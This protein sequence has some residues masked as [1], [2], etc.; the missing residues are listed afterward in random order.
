MGEKWDYRFLDMAK[1]VSTW[2][3]DPSTKVGA[4]IVDPKNRIVSVGYNGFPK[5]IK[6]NERLNSRELKYDIVLHAEQNCIL[7]ANRSLEGCIM[8]TYP[9]FPCSRC[10]S[11][12][13]QSGIKRLVSPTSSNER[14]EK[15]IKLSLELCD[16]VGISY[17]FY[18]F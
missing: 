16:E 1:L 11:Q 18:D 14:W 2:S 5:G 4:V 8:Y 17:T 9:M 13:I 6:D 10:C 12:I 15:S 7:F 3:K